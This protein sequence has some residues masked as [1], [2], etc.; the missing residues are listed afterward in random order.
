MSHCISFAS[1]GHS[2]T[3]LFVFFKVFSISMC[4]ANVFD[5]LKFT[6]KAS[7]LDDSIFLFEYNK[8][9]YIQKILK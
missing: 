5:D 3:N 6:K 1:V 2:L 9:K 7:L 8:L 4:H